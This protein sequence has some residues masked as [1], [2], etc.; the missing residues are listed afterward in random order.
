MFG[1]ILKAFVIRKLFGNISF[2]VLLNVLIKPVWL[3]LENDVQDK[4]GHED[5]GMY[6]ALF[7]LGYI[8]ASLTD[9]GLNQFVTKKLAS[10]P[11][12][13][14]EVFSNIFALKIMMLL[15]YPTL[16]S[17]AGFLLGYETREIYFLAILSFAQAVVQ[18]IFFFRANFQANQHFMVDSTA[19]VMDKFILILLVVIMLSQKITVDLFIYARLASLL[20][21][22]IIFYIVSVKL[23]DYIAPKLDPEKLKNLIKQSIPFAIITILYSL[24]EKIDSV[25]IDYLSRES[26]DVSKHGDAGLYAAAYRFLDAGMMYLWTILPIFFAKFA[27]HLANTGEKQKLLNFGQVVASVPMVFLAVFIFFYGELLFFQQKN[28]TPEQIATMANVLRI[29]FFSASL[30]GMFAIYSTLLTATGYEI[31]VS[32]MILGSIIINII[33]NITL[34]PIFGPIASAWV[35]VASTIFL[36]IAYVYYTQIKLEVAI[37]YAILIRLLIVFSLFFG[38]FY[39]LTLTQLPWYLVTML[40]GA[41][42]LIFSYMSGLISLML[43]RE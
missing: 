40:A 26:L 16:M 38:I 4:I 24:N 6:T 41:F 8:F 28:S 29:L 3:F 11:T 42:L 30:Q 32:K 20:V 5:F 2:V 21:T 1:H 23:F 25:I 36:S 22:V 35:T 43:S 10:E 13:I 17:A 19:S 34:I 37:P 33:G 39:L 18:L 9:I 12:R 7:S 27:Y 31:P 14:K 15:V